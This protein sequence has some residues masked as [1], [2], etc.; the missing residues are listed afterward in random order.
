MLPWELSTP[1]PPSRVES[2][3]FVPKGHYY[4]PPTSPSPCSRTY[5]KDGRMLS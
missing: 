1:L 2:Q 5:L 3:P 4:Q